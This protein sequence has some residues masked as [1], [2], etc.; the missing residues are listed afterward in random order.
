MQMYS[1]HQRGDIA[2]IT[3]TKRVKTDFVYTLSGIL[4]IDCLDFHYRKREQR[5]EE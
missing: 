3:N 2:K 4:C 5:R 1:N